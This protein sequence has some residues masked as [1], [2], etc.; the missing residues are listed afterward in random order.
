[1]HNVLPKAGRGERQEWSEAGKRRLKIKAYQQWLLSARSPE[2]PKE[3][4]Y[5]HECGLRKTLEK[6]VAKLVA[7]GRYTPVAE[8]WIPL[9][10]LED[11]GPQNRDSSAFRRIRSGSGNSYGPF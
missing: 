1:L 4:T 9:R 2:E 8:R 6:F 3:M 5:G 7:T 11:V 10:D